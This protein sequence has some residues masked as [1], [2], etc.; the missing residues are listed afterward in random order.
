MTQMSVFEAAMWTCAAGFML[1]GASF[2]LHGPASQAIA[3][4]S[5]VVNIIGSL[6]IIRHFMFSP[7]PSKTKAVNPV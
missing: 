6:L 1:M 2:V 5:S 3:A 7:P 4:V